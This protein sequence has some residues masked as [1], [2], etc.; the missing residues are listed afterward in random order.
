MDRRIALVGL[1]TIAAGLAGVAAFEL[2]SHAASATAYQS[3]TRL[4][5]PFTLVDQHG[6]A[7]TDRDLRGK[8]TVM[9]FGF[10]Y[11]PEVCPTTLT[12]LTAWMKALGPDA[13]KL[14]AVYVTIDPERDTPKQLAL[15][16]S[17]FDPRIRGLTGTP[18]Q[19][20]QIAHEYGVY[21]QKVPLDGG[22]YTM[23]HSSAVY[24]MDARGGFA[25]V[26]GY[27]EPSAQAVSQLRALVHT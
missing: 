5:G 10:T 13:D 27:Q 26:I 7:V 4:G 9:F 17:S 15:Y 6:R 1:V 8:P 14:N 3:S 22:G 2:R 12:A 21:Y 24:L 25:G 16:L 19:V 23:D 18:A 20:A 11:C